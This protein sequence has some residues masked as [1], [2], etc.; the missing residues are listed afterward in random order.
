ML[1]HH[2]NII[3]ICLVIFL[4]VNLCI[5]WHYSLSVFKR[6]RLLK[7]LV[8]SGIAINSFNPPLLNILFNS[9]ITQSNSLS[10]IENNAILVQ[11]SETSTIMMI[12]PDGFHHLDI[13]IIDQIQNIEFYQQI[14]LS[15][16]TQ[17]LLITVLD[18]Q[19]KSVENISV[20]LELVDYSHISLDYQT[21]HFGQIIYHYLPKHSRVY[22]EAICTKTKR[23]AFVDIDTLDYRNLTLILKDMNALHY[24]EY[25][26]SDK[27]YY[28][29]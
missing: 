20:H 7:T 11:L 1:Q 6:Q 22:I 19:Y 13:L 3:I 10:I 2:S 25:D 16:G 12:L 24:D 28:A 15:T 14:D 8:Y 27:G 21:N 29:L 26:L 23:Y 9:N 17:S 5:Y 18:Q 4:T